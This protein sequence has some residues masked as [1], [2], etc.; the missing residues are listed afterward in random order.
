MVMRG[1]GK[2]RLE[3]II[4]V[5]NSLDAIQEG[6]LERASETK[7]ILGFTV[8]NESIAEKIVSMKFLRYSVS[9]YVLTYYEAS[10]FYS[11][12]SVELMLLRSA[13]R[14]WG[15]DKLVEMKTKRRGKKG[16]PVLT[17]GWL[18][19][20]AGILKSKADIE[21][22]ERIRLMRNCYVHFQN[23]ILTSGL[24]LVQEKD[25]PALPAMKLQRINRFIQAFRA[26]V[27]PIYPGSKRLAS[28][29]CS[30]FIQKRRRKM[31]SMLVSD[32]QGITMDFP[33]L[34]RRVYK[35]QGRDAL[36]TIR[37]SKQLLDV[38]HL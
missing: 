23:Q 15:E 10:V 9:A 32:M 7:G 36:D 18:I 3:D 1:A 11:S 38:E 16:R 5:L 22:A 29:E 35:E 26:T 2:L 20:E 13:I 4:S 19:H 27:D 8:R 37:W 31:E 33:D 24:E 25:L 34:L 28:R 21:I 14:S 12:L 30:E 6:F 17:F